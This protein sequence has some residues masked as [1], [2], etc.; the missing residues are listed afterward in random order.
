MMVRISLLEPQWIN[1][2]LPDP[3]DHC[4]HGCIDMRID[5]VT[6]VSKDDGEWT[7][8]AAA[9]FLLRTIASNHNLDESVTEDNFLIPHCGHGVWPNDEGKYRVII[10]GCNE[11]IDMEIT[12][13]GDSI[14]IRKG[15]TQRTVLQRQWA[16][17]ILD[18]VEQI[19]EFYRTSGPKD[20]IEN[21]HDRQGWS[22]FWEEW[23]SLKLQAKS[24]AKDA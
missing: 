19:E 20:P 16:A 3:Q 12:H 2:E 13:V 18:F 5:D 22:L 21:D 6:L 1:G 9:L 7:V 14:Q 17:A 4:A 15:G 11:G 10:I 23:A 8:S 24:C